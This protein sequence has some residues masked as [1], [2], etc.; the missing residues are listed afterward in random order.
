MEKG[1]EI[2]GLLQRSIPASKFCRHSE[3]VAEANSASTRAKTGSFV[4]ILP[5]FMPEVDRL[6]QSK[7]CAFA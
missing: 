2:K 4:A 6:K 1:M 3:A 7:L 5:K